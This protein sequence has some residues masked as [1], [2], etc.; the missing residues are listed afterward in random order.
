MIELPRDRRED[1]RDAE[2]RERQVEP[3]EPQRG[4]SEDEPDPAGHGGRDRDRLHVLHAVMR[5]QDRGRVRAD[6][7]EGAL[8]ERDLPGGREH[9]EAEDRD[10][11]RADRREL[12]GAELREHERQ[13]GEHRDP[14]AERP[15]LGGHTRL[16]DGLAEEPARANEQDAEDHRERRREPQLAVDPVDV[17]RPRG[18][19]TTP[20]TSPPTTAPSGESMPPSRAAANE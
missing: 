20:S 9:V 19:K 13:H 6:R 14:G 17:A 16:A 4:H 2:R 10:E 5:H 18:C 1:D 7:D 11:V 15:E 3:R 12:H 8:A